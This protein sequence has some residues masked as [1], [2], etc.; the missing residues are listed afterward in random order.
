VNYQTLRECVID[1]D[2]AGAETALLVLLDEGADANDLLA[3]G[4]IP[5]MDVVGQ[6]FSRGEFFVPEMLTAARAMKACMAVLEPLL[7]GTERL[8]V[9]TVVLGTVKGDVHDIGKNIVATM[10]RGVGFEVLDLGVDVSTERFVEAVQEHRPDILALSALLT[11]T[12]PRMKDVITALEQAGL[13]Q[14]VIVLVGGA[15]LTLAYAESIG[16]DGYAAHAGSA[17]ERA[18]ELVEATK[19]TTGENG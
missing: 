9:G 8:V 15:P 7:V 4:L 5:A 13:R 16:A 11:T 19:S 6:N 14:Q 17:S 10:L 12:M 18:K 2:A 1:G 3:R